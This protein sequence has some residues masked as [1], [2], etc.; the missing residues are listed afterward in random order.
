M[1]RTTMRTIWWLAS[2]ACVTVPVAEGAVFYGPSPYL[3]FND[4]PF[5][6]MDFRYFHLEGFED[7]LLNVPGVT[8]STGRVF[9]R[10][11]SNDSVDADDGAIDGKGRT[12]SLWIDG[13]KDLVFTF[14]ASVLGSLPTHAGIVWTDVGTTQPPHPLGYGDVT[15]EAF[16]PSGASLG[17]IGPFLLGDGLY[18]GQTAEDRF[19][20]VYNPDGI[21]S[22]KISMPNLSGQPDNR[23]ANWEVDHLQY[24]AVYQCVPPAAPPRPRT[25][26]VGCGW[27]YY[28]FDW[29]EVPADEEWFWQ[30]E[31]CGT[32]TGNPRVLIA[33]G[34]A[35]RQGEAWQS[36]QGRRLQSVA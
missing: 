31:T 30:Y 19:F 26:S 21:S 23:A 16:G 1:K 12:L 33:R 11:T 35:F 18:E 6:G 28:W 10:G 3:S 2:L 8:A 22:I 17:V 5:K 34:A 15:F 24:G 29:N 20:G 25:G 7:G 13:V 27:A 36:D 9:N 14:N 4:S 32:N